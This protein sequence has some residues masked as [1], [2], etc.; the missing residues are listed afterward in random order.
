M[1][2][3]NVMTMNRKR[4]FLLLL[5]LSRFHRSQATY[6]RWSYNYDGNKSSLLK[7]LGKQLH[8]STLILLREKVTCILCLIFISHSWWTQ[9]Q[10]L[11]SNSESVVFCFWFRLQLVRPCGT[12]FLEKCIL[13]WDGLAQKYVNPATFVGQKLIFSSFSIDDCRK[14]C[15]YLFGYTM[16]VLI[17]P[18]L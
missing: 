6:V 10:L 16:G 7:F 9:L 18:D 8:F 3:R 13:F 11:L 17:T 5:Y 4:Q 15:L 2:H 1:N 14:Y 12:G